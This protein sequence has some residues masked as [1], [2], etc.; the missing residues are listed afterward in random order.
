MSLREMHSDVERVARSNRGKYEY[1]DGLDFNPGSELHD[2]VVEMVMDC[3]KRGY[4]TTTD[5]VH[6]CARMR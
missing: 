6:T 2:S 5:Y 3:A 1:P 4:E